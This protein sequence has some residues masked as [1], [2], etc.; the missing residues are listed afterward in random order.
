MFFTHFDDR[1][2][3]D[4]EMITKRGKLRLYLGMVGK[5]LI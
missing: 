2:R 1:L 3:F 4:L 5:V